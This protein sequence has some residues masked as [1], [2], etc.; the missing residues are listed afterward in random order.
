MNKESLNITV[1]EM[2]ILPTDKTMGIYKNNKLIVELQLGE[3]QE[4]M[5]CF[6]DFISIINKENQLQSVM[7]GRRLPK[8]K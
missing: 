7:K 8:K 1:G 6:F 5:A 2:S 4:L 3:A